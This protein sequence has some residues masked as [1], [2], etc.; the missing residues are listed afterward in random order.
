MADT[1]G[2]HPEKSKVNEDTL[3]DFIRAPIN[4]TL[5]EVSVERGRELGE[6]GRDFESES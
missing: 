1:D 4:G 3:S 2:F 6:S 5:T